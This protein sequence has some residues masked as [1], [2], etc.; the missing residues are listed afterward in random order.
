MDDEGPSKPGT[1]KEV[2]DVPLCQV[3]FGCGR[4]WPLI[5]VWVCFKIFG[6]HFGLG[7]FGVS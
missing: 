7:F 3:G 1:A 2:R 4:Y 5:A 6:L